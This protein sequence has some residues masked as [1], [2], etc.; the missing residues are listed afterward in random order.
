MAGKKKKARKKKKAKGSVDLTLKLNVELESGKGRPKQR[1]RRITSRRRQNL[2]EMRRG[3]GG[4]TAANLQKPSFFGNTA[5]L[6]NAAM[7]QINNQ[8][9]DT[10]QRLRDQAA[11]LKALKNA[12]PHAQRKHAGQ[13]Q[14][15]EQRVAALQQQ[16]DNTIAQFSAGARQ[17][18]DRVRAEI[19]TRDEALQQAGQQ[20]TG[21]QT[22]QQA[23]EQM[24]ALS[25]AELREQLTSKIGVDKDRITSQWVRSHKDDVR[26]YLLNPDSP[27]GRRIMKQ[28]KSSKVFTASAPFTDTKAAAEP[29]AQP[30]PEAEPASDSVAQNLFGTPAG[31]KFSMDELVRDRDTTGGLLGQLR[32][33]EVRARDR[34]RQQ[35]EALKASNVA[36]T[37]PRRPNQ[38]PSTPAEPGYLVTP[39]P[40][41]TARKSRLTP[42]EEAQRI[43][44][45]IDE[46]PQD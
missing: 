37:P 11:E 30:Q 17:V 3:M 43:L 39:A 4:L 36:P 8:K 6:S 24:K 25:V 5:L 2:R 14:V 29:Q 26:Q 42:M 15:L 18:G 22:A 40:L 27:A 35:R 21:L 28:L 32:L 20:L 41:R 16:Y 12:P 23:Q 9:Y 38:P 46:E 1:T 33:Q 10:E 45:E 31:V 19:Q 7:S 44:D 34:M 13:V